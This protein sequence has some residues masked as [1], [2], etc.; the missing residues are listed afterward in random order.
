MKITTCW[1]SVNWVQPG[2]TEG[3]LDDRP[4]Q[5]SKTVAPNAVTTTEL[6]NFRSSLREGFFRDAMMTFRE[7]LAGTSIVSHMISRNL[8][9]DTVCRCNQ[10]NGHQQFLRSNSITDCQCGRYFRPF[11]PFRENEMRRLQSL[12]NCSKTNFILGKSR[13]AELQ[14]EAK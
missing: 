1:T 9:E 13:I 10:S 8:W 11:S 7:P 5:P 4:P 6:P 3:M 12:E 2:V 14:I